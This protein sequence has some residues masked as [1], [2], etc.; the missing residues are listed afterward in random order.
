MNRPKSVKIGYKDYTVEEAPGP[1]MNNENLCYGYIDYTS[2][3]IKIANGHSKDVDD[4]TF[5]HECIHG[6]G[7][8]YDIGLSEA[9][10]AKLAGAFQAFIKDNPEV[11]NEV[12]REDTCTKTVNTIIMHLRHDNSDNAD[13]IRKII[14]SAGE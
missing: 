14:N 10:V 1:L 5:I 9:K 2:G 12:S 6:M 7:D 13:K 4:N 3:E 8:V 11:F